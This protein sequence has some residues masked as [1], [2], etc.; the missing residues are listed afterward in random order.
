VADAEVNISAL[1]LHAAKYLWDPADS[2][3]D[4]MFDLIPARRGTPA[5]FVERPLARSDTILFS[6]AAYITIALGI[7]VGCVVIWAVQNFLLP[8]LMRKM[9]ETAIQNSAS[10]RRNYIVA[11]TDWSL[12]SCYVSYPRRG[13]LLRWDKRALAD[14][15]ATLTIKARGWPK[16]KDFPEVKL[17]RV[18]P[19]QVPTHPDVPKQQYFCFASATGLNGVAADAL[20]PDP[21]DAGL[22][23]TWLLRKGKPSLRDGKPYQFHVIAYDSAGKVVEKSEWSRP[24]MMHGPIPFTHYPL[25]MWK[26]YCGILP[27]DTFNLFL[28]KF[29]L[30]IEKAPSMII[31]FENIK[32][33][34]VQSAAGLFCG[35]APTV[36]GDEGD[37][38]LAQLVKIM[39]STGADVQT[40]IDD[41][42][43]DTAEVPLPTQTAVERKPDNLKTAAEVF[44]P[45]G[46]FNDSLNKSKFFILDFGKNNK[47][48][49][50]DCP[51]GSDITQVVRIE[52]AVDT[53][54]SLN[55]AHTAMYQSTW[56]DM[57]CHAEYLAY[58]EQKR[59]REQGDEGDRSDRW[60]TACGSDASRCQLCEQVLRKSSTC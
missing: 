8:S 11:A 37:P 34:L 39:I 31:S 4:Y 56:Y 29:C 19:T 51:V 6:I 25:L 41:L 3:N 7:V 33:A 44:P 9:R 15:F 20:F 12:N 45:D 30:G 24:T 49:A 59:R 35:A 42:Y 13:A 2:S 52:A 32:L 43:I 1:G 18:D 28:N 26:A 57:S 40:T 10:Y 55:T 46:H 50:L 60:S 58:G 53:G 38:A 5:H 23:G 14:R 47:K 17:E 27:S 21:F 22:N 48:K 54:G 36:Y 16:S